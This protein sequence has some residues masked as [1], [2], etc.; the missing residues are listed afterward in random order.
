MTGAVRVVGAEVGALV[1]EGPLHPSDLGVAL[2]IGILVAIG[3]RRSR[4]L[5]AASAVAGPAGAGTVL[6]LAVVAAAVGSLGRNARFVP[7][8][9]GVAI[10][11]GVILA[12]SELVRVVSARASRAGLEH[13]R[14]SL[15]V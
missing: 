12:S 3:F 14:R 1:P 8:V 5:V 11:I 4:W 7:A 9:A 2:L 15:P 6:A 10:V 13:R